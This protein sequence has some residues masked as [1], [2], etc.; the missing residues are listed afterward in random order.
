MASSTKTAKA[1]VVRQNGGPEVLK[2]E[3]VAIPVPKAG[4]VV[5]RVLAA[6]VN[7]L[8]TYI[9]S[10]AWG[11][12]KEPYTPGN[13]DVAGEIATL[14]EGVTNLKVGQRVFTSSTLTG[15][16]A[17]YVLCDATAAHPLPDNITFDQ[18]AAVNVAYGTAYNALIQNLQAKPG[19]TVLVH[20]GS[21][22]VGVAS[23][24]I[25]VNHRSATYLDEIRAFTGGRGV[26][27]ILEMVG[28]NLSKDL[29][30]IAP[31]GKI[32]IIGAGHGAAEIQP[33]QI[34]MS[35]VT[36]V[37]IATIALAPEEV[38]EIV[39]YLTQGLRQGSLRPIVGKS[40]PL[41]DAPA[42]HAEVSGHAAGS[43]G[44]VILHP[45]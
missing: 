2:L 12:L 1:I 33:S 24:Q 20:G 42:A 11:P 26:D 4:Q 41:A 40:F 3:D 22:G 18:G 25:A 36:I 16:Y 14:G 39:A 32:A 5:V 45:W 37:G 27:L 6:G 31:K 9:R 38:T 44:K 30:I 17:Q 21:G 7:P 29:S 23:I 34:L 15:A 8:E 19:Q 13:H 28:T 10:G 43:A 35:R